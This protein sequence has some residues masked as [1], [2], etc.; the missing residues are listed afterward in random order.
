MPEGKVVAYAS[1]AYN[2]CLLKEEAYCIRITLDRDDPIYE[3]DVDLPV[4]NLLEKN[5]Y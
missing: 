2:Y 4:V 3:K 1:F 5:F